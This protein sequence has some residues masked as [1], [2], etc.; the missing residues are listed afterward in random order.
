MKN[1]SNIDILV[2]VFTIVFIVAEIFIL[3]LLFNNSISFFDFIYIT[4]SLC[5]ELFLIYI[6][7]LKTKY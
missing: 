3:Y 5:I 7:K 2:A 1:K 4:T 6:I